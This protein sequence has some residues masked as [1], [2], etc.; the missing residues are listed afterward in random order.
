MLRRL[1]N[2]L[3]RNLAARDESRPM[4]SKVDADPAEIARGQNA[5]DAG[6]G[7]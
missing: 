6:G 2:R 7:G 3:M 1:W 4:I 5:W